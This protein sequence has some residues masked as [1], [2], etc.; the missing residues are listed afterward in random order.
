MAMGEKEE[1]GSA[2][3]LSLGLCMSTLHKVYHW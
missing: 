1:K 3:V 2:V